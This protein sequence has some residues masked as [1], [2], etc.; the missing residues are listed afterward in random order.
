MP[1]KQRFH[2]VD[3]CNFG[4]SFPLLL[5]STFGD[6]QQRICGKEMETI[7]PKIFGFKVSDLA[8]SGPRA[9]WLRMK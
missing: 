8:K 2:N 3:G 5:T 6:L 4:T 7:E 1:A 9:Q